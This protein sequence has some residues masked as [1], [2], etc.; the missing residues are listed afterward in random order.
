MNVI[1]GS[2]RTRKRLELQDSFKLA[3]D[4]D[5]EAVTLFA[6]SDEGDWQSIASA[7]LS[8]AD[9][10]SEI[11]EV[12][13][14]ATVRGSNDSTVLLWLPE[15]QILVR[16]LLLDQRGKDALAEAGRRV[17]SET[18][19]AFEE[20]AIA[21]GESQSG[22][23]TPVLAALKQTVV[24]AQEYAERWGFPK[25]LVSTRVGAELFGNNAP[26]FRLPEASVRRAARVSLR[27]VA[28]VAAAALVGIGIYGA[29]SSVEPLLDSTEPRDS[30]GPVFATAIVVDREH[31]NIP[32]PLNLVRFGQPRTLAL[33]QVKL[34]ST[35]GRDSAALTSYGKIAD[36]PAPDVLGTPS[37]EPQMKIGPVSIVPATAQPARLVAPV[38][39][40]TK[41][42]IEGL[43]AS[44]D[45][46]RVGGGEKLEGV[47]AQTL[48]NAY[49][50]E[51]SS[52]QSVVLAALPSPK[53][54]P[55]A[56]QAQQLARSNP[57]EDQEDSLAA[58]KFAPLEVEIAPLPRPELEQAEV[59]IANTVDEPE[60]E[61]QPS[62]DVETTEP[63][64]TEASE[65]PTVFAALAA[66]KPR[67]RPNLPTVDQTTSS[68]NFS[69]SRSFAP[70]SVKKA[71]AEYGL[72]LQETSLIGI[73]DA[74]SGRHALVRLPSGDYRKL[75][76]G[77]VLDGWRVNSIS[78]EAMR[79]SKRGQN[80][81]L[82][83]VSR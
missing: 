37:P 1:A 22:E 64:T 28:S 21:L 72:E 80:R 52:S 74:R 58:T 46:I 41:G 59:E 39:N 51:S 17:A 81:T 19:H 14:E 61:A 48:S 5:P 20:L 12:R 68:R 8:S 26:I 73:F 75:A 6:R 63:E 24:E 16:Q 35:F 54:D 27:A 15:D 76:R 43:L 60:T 3:L 78:R 70:G 77:D 38:A 40:G 23:P 29:L 32:A 34:A 55:V 44:I 65:E 45:R 10:S 66:P 9:F 36:T 79:L 31:S 71:A 33:Q 25:T 62:Q 2:R 42:K 18:P 56:P 30:N 49:Q 69:L 83:L 67:I 13:I 57:A 11:D 82:L 50:S 4:L 53:E 7:N 47:A